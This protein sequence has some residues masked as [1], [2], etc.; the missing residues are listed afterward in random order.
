MHAS[1]P[2]QHVARVPIGHQSPR[3][4]HATS[5]NNGNASSLFNPDRF[6]NLPADLIGKG[7]SMEIT[8]NQCA[9]CA[10]HPD[11]QL[12]NGAGSSSVGGAIAVTSSGA[13]VGSSTAAHANAA[14]E[15]VDVSIGAG[16]RCVCR[17]TG[18]RETCVHGGY[19]ERSG[20]NR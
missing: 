19:V 7:E 5:S 18:S 4:A 17:P 8:A 20:Q 13:V 12:N 2:N 3:A 10:I 15:G 16:A 14:L 9:A 11:A 6:V 1:P